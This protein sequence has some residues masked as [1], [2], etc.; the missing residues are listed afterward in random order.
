MTPFSPLNLARRLFYCAVFLACAAF[1]GAMPAAAEIELSEA[2]R[3]YLEN[4]GEICFA[5]DPDWL[6]Y[7][8]IRDG[9]YIG[10]AADYMAL[11]QS[12]VPAAFKLRETKTWQETVDLMKGGD[13]DFIPFLNLT[14]DRLAYMTFTEPYVRSPQ[15]IITSKQV[16]LVNGLGGL[17]GR[18]VAVTK[19]Y[20]IENILRRDHPQTNLLYV[21]NQIEGLNAVSQ[22]RAFALVGSLIILNHV[23]R[24]EGLTNLKISGTTNLDNEYRIGIRKEEPMLLS[25]MQKAVASVS[26]AESNAIFEK[27]TAIEY[28]RPVDYQ[29]IGRIIALALGALLL[30][31]AYTWQ[32]RKRNRIIADQNRDLENARRQAEEAARIDFLT[33]VANR[34]AFYEQAEREIERVKRY[35]HPL[36]I[37]MLDID[38]FKRINDENGHDAGDEVLKQ[39]AA[40][41]AETTRTTDTVARLGG[42]EFVILLPET[43]LAEAAEFAN[44]LRARIEDTPTTYNGNTIRHTA[45]LGVTA[46]SETD[47]DQ[48]LARCD[49][50]L[51]AA[52]SDGRNR[53]VSG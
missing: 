7:E 25:I 34:R 17:D 45:S 9:K 44:R 40:L 27:W 47:I 10:M 2:E 39:V 11:F 8:A 3:A 4:K 32:I 16:S 26:E 6:P 35:A 12:R 48:T 28:T 36:S 15:V 5:V 43:E 51:Y 53:V 18:T 13:C 33:Q 14:E 30:L 41:L 1:E 46:A 38:H 22:G 20:R 31:G 23:I 24:S 52:K 29:L 50:L 49:K 37:I 21:P 42:E 19:G